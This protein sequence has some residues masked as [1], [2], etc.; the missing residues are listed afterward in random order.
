MIVNTFKHHSASFYAACDTETKTYV[1][2]YL[3]TSEQIA[4]MCAAKKD[5]EYMYPVS[6]WR[7]H[8]EV[9]CWAYITWT[10]EGWAIAETFEEFAEILTRYRITTAWFYN[11]PF[12]FSIL[13]WQMLSRGWKHVD[14]AKGACEYSELSNDF[15]CR[16]SMDCVFPYTP[17]KGEKTTRTTWRVRFYDLRNIFHGGLAQLLEDFDVTGDDGKPIRKLKMDYQNA[18]GNDASDLEYMK[19]DAMGL[20]YLIQEAGELMSRLYGY[21][22]RGRKPEV[23]T[24][25]GLAKKVVLAEMYPRKEE[26]YRMMQFRREHPITLEQDAFFR[27]EGLLGGGCVI[28]NPDYQGKHLHGISAHRYDVNSEYPYYMANMRSIWGHP[29]VYKTYEDALEWNLPN[30]CYIFHITELYATVKPTAVPAW[31][32]PYTGK[33]NAEYIITASDSPIFMF[34]EELAEL[35]RHW[36]DVDKITVDYVV[37]YRTKL[38]PAIRRVMLREYD[39]KTDARNKDETGRMTF[40]KLIMNGYGGKYSQNP[41][42]TVISRRMDDGI[43]RM[44]STG[45]ETDEKS[46]MQ[47]VQGARITSGGRTYLMKKCREVCG[48]DGIRKNLLYTDTDSI[49][50]LST[51]PRTSKTELGA[52]KEENKT[53][54]VAA[55][56]L[57]PK[58]YYEIEQ[59]GA[60]EL[61]AKGIH[62][63]EID[64]LID[65]G[66]PIEA[67]YSPGY[68]VQTLSALNVKGGKALLPLPKRLCAVNDVNDVDEKYN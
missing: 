57:A 33:K 14:K 29:A 42:R 39:G 4:A 54:I 64:K 59:S 19:V 16:Y 11:A 60:R 36:Y 28:L 32:D 49:H 31:R 26:R 9:R 21:D 68:A 66:T 40:H 23:L 8:A 47:V 46:L 53:P 35:M 67:I 30:D 5:G 50:A 34:R 1:D 20:W 6:W 22:I 17:E 45:E 52:L 62:I 10:P 15:G 63:E 37:V 24:A 7:E 43:V 27:R 51:A 58:T 12:D 2:G 18:D 55:C 48:N 3:L 65:S 61:H 56:Y 41:N 25:S 38:E 13:D 44:I